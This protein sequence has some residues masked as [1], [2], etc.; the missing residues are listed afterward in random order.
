[1]GGGIGITPMI[2][3]A[4]RLHLL[5]RDFALHYSAPTRKE[6]AFLGMLARVPWAERVHFHISAEGTR[7]DFPAIL[8]QRPGAHLYTCGP[9]HYMEA[10]LAAAREAGF[11]DE[12]LH[13]EYFTPP[14]TPEYENHPFTLR[15]LRSG[16]EIAVTADQSATD[17]L[18]EA[19]VHVD[20]KCADGLC[21]VCRCRLVSGEAEHRDFVLSNAE[22]KEKII[23][24]QSRAAKPGGVL[25]IDL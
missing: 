11:P 10:V 16:R 3:M 13:R 18:S 14:E 9:D 17:A 2:A 21:G 8:R 22:R 24:C 1:M 15:L 6:A 19:G 7:A 4:H 12:A 25:E 5:G 20:V 23:L